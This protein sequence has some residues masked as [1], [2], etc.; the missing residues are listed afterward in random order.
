MSADELPTTQK[1]GCLR[2]FQGC[3]VLWLLLVALPTTGGLIY[4]FW[5]KQKKAPDYI[6]KAEAVLNQSSDQSTDRD[7]QPLGAKNANLATNN[8]PEKQINDYDLDTTIYAIYQIEKALGETKSFQDLTSFVIQ[9]DSEL[10]ARDV[11]WLK[12]SLFNT[13][14]N[15]LFAGEDK[16]EIDSMMTFWHDIK[17]YISD[18]LNTVDVTFVGV[19]PVVKAGVGSSPEIQ[20]KRLD[21]SLNKARLRED[22]KARIRS[23][24][25]QILQ[26]FFDYN[27]A[28]NKY[29]PLWERLCS[30]R[31]EAYYATYNGQWDQAIQSATEAIKISPHEKEAH[32]L[33]AL[34]LIESTQLPSVPEKEALISIPQSSGNVRLSGAETI[35]DQFLVERDSLS[36]SAIL[37]KGVI[38]MKKGDPNKA[39]VY[40]DQAAA[41]FPRNKEALD[42]K[43]NL[44]KK[45]TYLQDSKQGVRLRTLYT[46]MMSGCGYF[47]PEFQK[48]RALIAKGDTAS[49]R[50]EI[51][52]HFQRRKN[53][54]EWSKILDDFKFSSAFLGTQMTR[55]D[56]FN[57]QKGVCLMVSPSNYL[58][59]LYSNRIEIAVKNNSTTD[60][61]NVSL[62]FCIRFT[63]MFKHDYV[64]IPLPRTIAMLKAGDELKDSLTEVSEKTKSELGK[65]KSF[66]DII[67]YG[68]IL[69][70]DE[71]IIWLSNQSKQD[72]PL[73]NNNQKINLFCRTR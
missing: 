36:A 52:D 15:L 32:L 16:K 60:L 2:F 11:S 13:Y 8:A 57:E 47:S 40:F 4:Y 45:R 72:S 28:F 25:N 5:P 34:A 14:K 67:D 53:Q 37:L 39:I 70:S 59:K 68:A 24:Q 66:Q 1:K 22:I 63:D 33:L 50:E 23:A 9:K 42:D 43:L 61:H 38:E 10:V 29:M 6:V 46:S 21:E 44:Y 41:Y 18:T 71:A 69:I 17:S 3:L 19:A 7:S 31:D 65:Q 48:A 26:F 62:L 20:K 64:T 51:F 54:E 73:G 35:V 55:I 49:A 56:S 58:T 12:K 27:T 30:K